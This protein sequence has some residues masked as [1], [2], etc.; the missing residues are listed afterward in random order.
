[1]NEAGFFSRIF[2]GGANEDETRIFSPE[3][4]RME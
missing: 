3:E 1:M 2:G 4:L